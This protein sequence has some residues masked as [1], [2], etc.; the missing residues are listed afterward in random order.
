[1]VIVL[2]RR[3]VRPDREDK[4]LA[5][6]R[7]QTPLNN[8]DFLGETLTKVLDDIS[9]PAPLRS[10]AVGH[11]SC[12]TYINVAKWK[13]WESFAQHFADQIS[14]PGGFDPEIEIAPRERAVL[15]TI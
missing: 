8:S 2:I 6:Y 10:F 14:K 1:M 11:P 5:T 7:A 15:G 4:F 9:L 13:S 12:V 3:F